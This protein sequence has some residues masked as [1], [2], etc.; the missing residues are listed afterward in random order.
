VVGHPRYPTVQLVDPESEPVSVRFALKIYA[1]ALFDE[2]LVVSKCA[3]QIF[4]EALV[5][6]DK[7]TGVK[8]RSGNVNPIPI[9]AFSVLA[10]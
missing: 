8:E 6:T 7:F 2:R 3:P 10:S 4:G 1:V 5:R 9:N